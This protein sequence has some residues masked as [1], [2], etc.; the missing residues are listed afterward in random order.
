MKKLA[1]LL[2]LLLVT[3][4]GS[5]QT[6]KA[7]FDDSHAEDAG[8]AD[9]VIDDNMPVPS[10][11]QSGITSSTSQTYWTGAISAWGVDLVKRGFTVHTLT[12]SYGITYGNSSNAYDLSNYNLFVVCEPNIKF[13]ADEKTAIKT[14]VQNGGGLMMVSDHYGADRNNDGMDAT[15]IWDALPTDSLFGIHFQTSG[16]SNNDISETSTNVATGSDPLINGADG[17]VTGLAYHNGT[18]MTILPT[19]N[20]N[21]AGHIWM[22]GASHGNSQIMFATSKYG[23]G[24][25]AG[26]GD[27]S[28]ADDGSARPN[29]S[30]IYN[31]WGEAG[32]TDSI[33]FLNACL[34][35]VTPDTVGQVT[36]VY[37]A[38]GATGVVLPVA[39][40]WNKV[41]S[42]TNYEFDLSFSSSFATTVASDTT[43]TDTTKTVSGLLSDTVYYWRVRA[44]NS[45]GWGSYSTVRNFRSGVTVYTI[46]ASAG[47]NGSISPSGSVSVNSGASQ[48]FTIS[49]STGYHVDS[50]LV[51]GVN[52]G[53]VT[54]YTFS[55]VTAGH[56]IRAVFRVNQ[57][58]IVAAAG[59]NGSLSPLGTATV[60]YG[61]NQTYAFTPSTG[62]H[63]DSVIV[64]GVNQTSASSYAFT[65][66]IASHTIRVTFLINTYTITATAGANGLINPSGTVAVN[67]G[68]SQ[69]FDFIPST[70]YHVDSILVDGVNQPLAASYAFTNVTANHTVRVAFKINSFTITGT[71][72]T[73]GSISPSGAVNVDSNG[74]Q[75]FSF[76]PA[77][78]YH[79][80]SLIIDSVNQAPVE[81]Y[82]FTNIIADHTIR[83][84]FAVNSYTLTVN[85]SGGAVTRQPDIALYLFGQNV[86]LT[87]VPT[88]GYTFSRWT[89]A[90]P[91]GHETDSPLSFTIDSNTTLTAVFIRGAYTLTING[92]NGM[93]LRNP[94]QAAYDSGATVQLTAVPST[95]YHF[96]GWSGDAAGTS[97]PLTIILDSPKT[98]TA[99]FLADSSVI[100][101]GAGAHGSI[102]PSG[103]VSVVNGGS[104]RFVFVPDAGYS[105]DSVIV[106]GIPVTDSLQGYTFVSVAA[107][108]NLSVTFARS[109]VRAVVHKTRGW[110]L[111]SLPVTVAD[112]R[113]QT[114]F[115]SASSQ[116]Y[117][118][119]GQYIP[120][121]TLVPGTGYWIKFAEAGDTVTTGEVITSGS[122]TVHAG[123]NMIGSISAPVAASSITSDPPNIT[124]GQFFGY[125]QGYVP[126]DTL[127]P[128]KG[129]WVKIAEDG[130][131]TLSTDS[132]NGTSHTAQSR[133]KIV[134]NSEKPPVPPRE[135]AA[136]EPAK[137]KA[138][139]LEQ[140]Y[141]N[142][143]NPVTTIAYTLSDDS[144]VS[145]RI[146][147][148]MGQEIATLVDETQQAGSRQ[149]QWSPN[150]LA[151]GVYYYR[152]EA[153][154]VEN[155]SKT[156]SQIKKMLLIR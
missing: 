71:A 120:S 9:W 118:Y 116:A 107:N 74:T 113:L 61:G 81:S 104:Q 47:S 115:P 91:A 15:Q 126:S 45:S 80:D 42:A 50:V 18:T 82:T 154:S 38:S 105:T 85:A 155:P 37:P 100:T 34:W 41:T 33:V 57:Y 54:G 110:N 87:A 76:T 128:V 40:R 19:F 77:T 89:G 133:I 93:V 20:S 23:K 147:N 10:P 11:A 35:L 6:Y 25:V 152:L 17:T 49:P 43:L 14:F 101:A 84:T 88:D 69:T 27:S 1:L 5:A 73:N 63:V 44:K 68:G 149:V 48:S 12:S 94:N 51:D 67:Y 135:A 59:S 142:P 146:Y 141:P 96:G 58:Q 143:F 134:A 2:C 30:S 60:N 132:F 145:L 111:S 28:P 97:N 122:V 75:A 26:V 139:A 137:P 103:S 86:Q 56:T 150:Q 46:T 117:A 131:L 4:G 106:D 98:L 36:L 65:N 79:V 123:W 136:S 124:T 148:V 53:S 32:A 108:H 112:P 114:I 31:G 144:K 151:S 140:A 7:L 52:Q 83:V 129:Y 24:K 119:S 153:L 8:N 121:D 62:Y 70:G 13:T 102:N 16:E 21:A 127:Y 78:G 92:Q 3:Y 130:V 90:V 39:F 66:V 125:S 64:D 95:G 138:Y 55:A 72:G 99:I 22:T 29:N 156:F 109:I